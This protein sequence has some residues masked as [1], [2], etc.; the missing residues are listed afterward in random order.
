MEAVAVHSHCTSHCFWYFLIYTRVDINPFLLLL[1]FLPLQSFSLHQYSTRI[2]W[3]WILFWFLKLTCAYN[4][5]LLGFEEW[6]DSICPGVCNNHLEVNCQGKLWYFYDFF[7]ELR[8]NPWIK[9][10]VYQI[11]ITSFYKFDATLI[12]EVLTPGQYKALKRWL[13]NENMI[14]LAQALQ[15]CQSLITVKM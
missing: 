13:T 6:L 7:V 11:N 4:T 10:K 9:K 1:S 8:N 5:L 15:Q 2:L 3:R 14:V 12:K